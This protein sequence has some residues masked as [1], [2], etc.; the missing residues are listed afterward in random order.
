MR[1]TLEF[2]A[3]VNPKLGCNPLGAAS[4]QRLEGARVGQLLSLPVHTKSEAAQILHPRFLHLP[5]LDHKQT[6]FAQT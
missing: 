3:V 4:D 2:F 1:W 5:L 6:S